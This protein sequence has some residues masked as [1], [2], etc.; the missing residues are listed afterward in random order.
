M[1]AFV[2]TNIFDGHQLIYKKLSGTR[3][4]VNVVLPDTLYLNIMFDD[5]YRAHFNNFIRICLEQYGFIRPS[6]KISCDRISFDIMLTIFRLREHF[7]IIG[8]NPGLQIINLTSSMIENKSIITSKTDPINIALTTYVGW[9]SRC[10]IDRLKAVCT[11]DALALFLYGMTLKGVAPTDYRSF[12][13]PKNM[14]KFL[15]GE[16]MIRS[17]ISKHV[18]ASIATSEQITAFIHSSIKSK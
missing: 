14:M 17:L 15:A 1:A 7:H 11:Y 3:N 8:I 5:K 4:G 16:K 13:L 18:M 9:L 6:L 10:T 2:L 12:V